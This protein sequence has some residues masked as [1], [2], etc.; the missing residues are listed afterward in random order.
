MEFCAKEGQLYRQQRANFW[1]VIPSSL[2]LHLAR[3]RLFFDISVVRES[4]NAGRALHIDMGVQYAYLYDSVRFRRRPLY[5][6][7][8]SMYGFQILRRKRAR[9]NYKVQ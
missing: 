4:D 7:G 6:V 3:T 9:L 8:S 1:K 2:P 5:A